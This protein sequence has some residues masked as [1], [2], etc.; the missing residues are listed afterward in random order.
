[1]QQLV[2]ESLKR[3]LDFFARPLVDVPQFVQQAAQFVA[4]EFL[5]LLLEALDGRAGD[6]MV[7]IGHEASR[8]FCDN[9]LGFRP[10]LFARQAVPF[11]RILEIIDA[12]EIHVAE[13]P[14]D[15]IEIARYR[16]VQDEQSP[17]GA[18]MVNVLEALGRDHRFAE[19][20]S[21]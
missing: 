8:F 2:D 12:I 17:L 16:Q 7:H 9:L 6:A 4:L 21:C 15:R 11:A 10:F 18:L 20:P 3:A 19:H 13:L 1:M 14:D 5:G